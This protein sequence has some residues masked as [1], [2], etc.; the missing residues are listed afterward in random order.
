RRSVGIGRIGPQLRTSDR[1]RRAN[2]LLHAEQI[3]AL[4]ELAYLR[5]LRGV[6][7]IDLAKADF[8]VQ[9]IGICS[10]ADCSQVIEV[11]MGIKV[12]DR[13]EEHT[14][15]TKLIDAIQDALRPEP[16]RVGEFSTADT[17]PHVR[18]VSELVRRAR[19]S[20]R[21][22]PQLPGPRPPRSLCRLG[23]GGAAGTSRE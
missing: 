8:E 5:C 9:T 23:T 6:E 21:H 14:V 1:M 2:H 12:Q 10:A 7:R 13:A 3:V 20:P 4:T 11:Q 18:V 17:K 19:P 16:G 15:E 22:G